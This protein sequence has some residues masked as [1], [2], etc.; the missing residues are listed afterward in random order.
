MGGACGTIE[1]KRNTERVCVGKPEGNHH[2]DDLGID[3]NIILKC[4][5]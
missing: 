2:L 4:L 3:V 5:L 1:E